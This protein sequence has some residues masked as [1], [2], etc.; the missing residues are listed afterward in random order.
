MRLSSTYGLRGDGAKQIPP[1]VI[2]QFWPQNFSK[3]C[4][5]LGFYNLTVEIFINNLLPKSPHANVFKKIMVTSIF[6]IL[7]TK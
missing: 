6:L 4:F 3:I 5:F 7:A 2:F 1:R